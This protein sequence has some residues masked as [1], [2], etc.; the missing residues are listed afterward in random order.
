MAQRGLLGPLAADTQAPARRLHRLS[1]RSCPLS[2]YKSRRGRQAASYT[3]S[4]FRW[5]DSR[6]HLAKLATPLALVWSWPQ[7]DPATLAP[8][9]V[10]VA[11]DPDG[12]WY[13]TVYVTVHVQVAD[14]VPL[15]ATGRAVGIDL[16]LTDFA[17]LFAVLGDGTRIAN[18]RHLE[19]K[20]ANLARCQRRLARKQRGS[21]NW[22]K[23]AAKL[24]RAHR[25]VR[26]ARTD[27]L[28]R[29]STRLVREHD[30]LVIEDLH[31]RGMVRNHRLARAI[32]DTGWASFRAML[33]YKAQRAGRQ[34]IVV[35][36]YPV[37]ENL[38]GLRA[39]ACAP[40]HGHPCGCVRPAAP[41]TTGI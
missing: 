3:P 41:G 15:A 19:R 12:R 17:V 28:H 21:A 30:L 4:A 11:W 32:S 36:R 9:S 8:T 10:S 26:A 39:P 6:L 35:D 1:R 5:R 2:R 23:A 16:G 38:L 40:G 27:F 7:L 37:L 14:P 34:L 33:A 20:A 31:V 29:V 13:V 24:A 22:A 25:K 18:P